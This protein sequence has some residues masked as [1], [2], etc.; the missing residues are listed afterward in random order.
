MTV[1]G[2]FLDE[3][4]D[5]RNAHAAL[6]E[7]FVDRVLAAQ[8]IG[9]E[10]LGPLTANV[11]LQRLAALIGIDIPRRPPPTLPLDPGHLC[12]EVRLEPA[13]ISASHSSSVNVPL[14]RLV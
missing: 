4:I 7:Q 12:I 9:Q 10:A 5:V 13:L 2:K 8:A 6:F 3:A 1:P 11:A 14:P